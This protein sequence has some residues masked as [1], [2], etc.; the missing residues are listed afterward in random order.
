[1][2]TS[3]E[4]LWRRKKGDETR[5]RRNFRKH[6]L[7]IEPQRRYF[8]A[9]NRFSPGRVVFQESDSIEKNVDFVLSLDYCSLIE[10]ETNQRDLFDQ[11]IQW[12][13]ENE[14]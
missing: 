9:M 5:E 4:E 7:L 8:E 6:L 3:T 11:I 12:L 2:Q 14:T 10:H 1:L 13:R